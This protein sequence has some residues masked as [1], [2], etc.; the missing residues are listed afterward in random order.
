LRGRAILVVGGESTGTRLVTRLCVANGCAGDDEHDQRWDH[1]LPSP[2]DH[3]LIV[4]RRSIPHGAEG[5]SRHF[6]ELPELVRQLRSADYDV[7]LLVATRCWR[8][9]V[10]SQ[11]AMNH[12]PSE[13]LALENLR[14]AYLITIPKVNRMALQGGLEVHFVAYEALRDPRAQVALLGAIGIPSRATLDVTDENAKHF[15]R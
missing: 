5:H 9:T 12:V 7:V 1:G 13:A 4:W 3:P 15:E 6:P 10:K 11:V 2:E 8:A 14:K